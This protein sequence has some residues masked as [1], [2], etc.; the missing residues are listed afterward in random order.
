M[1]S[2]I[3][4]TL[5]KYRRALKEFGLLAREARITIPQVTSI[6]TKIQDVEARLHSI[7]SSSENANESAALDV[8]AL[9]RRSN[10]LYARLGN[11]LVSE[12][13]L[14][15][16]PPELQKLVLRIR[17]LK[18]KQ[19]GWRPGGSGE[20][21]NSEIGGEGFDSFGITWGLVVTILVVEIIVVAA[22]LI[23]P[24]R[25][26][27]ADV[28]PA[29]STE[30]DAAAA[31]PQESPDTTPKLPTS[32]QDTV[33]T[34]DI[35]PNSTTPTP[36][37]VA[38]SHHVARVYV[39]ANASGTKSGSTWED[40]CTSFDGAAAVVAATDATEIWVAKGVYAG[41]GRIPPNVKVLCGFRGT[42]TRPDA[43]S[44]ETDRVILEASINGT[45][46]FRV[47]DGSEVH[48]LWLGG[49]LA[50]NSADE[51]SILYLESVK[52]Q[53]TI[54]LSPGQFTYSGTISARMYR[55]RERAF[56]GVLT[57][58]GSGSLGNFTPLTREHLSS[59][60]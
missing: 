12:V 9:E 44:P 16:F 3:D 20:A 30:S 36:A 21:L 28:F 57:V 40:A 14:E 31:M 13:L 10:E 55:I 45:S 53:A 41:S 51:A 5:R 27:L 4:D 6:L 25:E 49:V 48:G 7:R 26:L 15:D 35:D 18:S 19:V 8:Q 38:E 17:N 33:A 34:N 32:E 1:N 46:S 43:A 22:C 24:N 56:R 54:E 47:G 60:L 42:E 23:V 50:F 11:V 58:S 59:L 29:I 37:P 2:E 52:G 39:K